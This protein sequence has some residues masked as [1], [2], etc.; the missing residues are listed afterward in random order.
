MLVLIHLGKVVPYTYISR[1]SI[2]NVEMR[3]V[4]CAKISEEINHFGYYA[5]NG[6]EREGF[7]RDYFLSLA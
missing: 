1:I 4:G 7:F 6:R 3:D 2:M 5:T